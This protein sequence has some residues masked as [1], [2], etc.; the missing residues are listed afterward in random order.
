MGAVR[1]VATALAASVTAVSALYVN[2]SVIAPCDSPIYCHGDILEQ[3][4][5]A[6]P[7]SD[8]KTFV[9]MYVVVL[10]NGPLALTRSQASHSISGRDPRGI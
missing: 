4:E 1:H 8:S 5:L 9:D 2:G 10:F 7:F 6:Q 3:V